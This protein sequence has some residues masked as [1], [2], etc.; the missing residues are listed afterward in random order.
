MIVRKKALSRRSVLRGAGATLALPLLDA[1]IPA[2]TAW[3]ATPAVPVRRLG[4]NFLFF[5][6]L[7]PNRNCLPRHPGTPRRD[8]CSRIIAFILHR[9][10]ATS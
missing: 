2:M 9:A 1:M 3:G 7:V 4:N 6:R 8:D 10:A 5:N